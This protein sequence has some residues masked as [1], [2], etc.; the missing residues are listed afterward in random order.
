MMF[1]TYH[2]YRKVGM[3]RV[4]AVKGQI[5]GLKLAVYYFP[6]EV[7]YWWF[8]KV[9]MRRMKR[10]DPEECQRALKRMQ[11]AVDELRGI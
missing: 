7:R 3:T 11:D 10:R 5:H 6:S 4:A 8:W 1:K 2:S 9:T